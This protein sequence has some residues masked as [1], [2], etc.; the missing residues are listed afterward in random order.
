[1]IGQNNILSTDQYEL[2]HTEKFEAVQITI[3]SIFIRNMEIVVDGTEIQPSEPMF[4]QSPL[5]KF[6]LKFK[7]PFW[8]NPLNNIGGF[9]FSDAAG[10]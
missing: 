1:M 9:T 2:V 3:P 7:T 6:M 5:F 10:T 8:T 4:P